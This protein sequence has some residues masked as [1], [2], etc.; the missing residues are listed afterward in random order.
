M[1][2]SNYLGL[3]LFLILC[4]SCD[5]DAATVIEEPILISAITME[6]AGFEKD[7]MGWP[8]DWWHK[9]EP[10]EVRWDSDQAY[11]GDGSVAIESDTLVDGFNFWGQTMAQNVQTGRKLR[12]RVKVKLDQVRGEGVSI[13]IRG[14][15][16]FSPEGNAEAFVT[17]QGTV[18]ISGT[19]N[20]QEYQVT[21]LE[22]MPESI[23]SI[24]VYLVL[25]PNTT[26]TVWFDEVKLEY[27]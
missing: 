16:T 18:Y 6:N 27:L 14:D 20:W 13:V 26:G 8:S 9:T 25:L 10:Y 2:K 12:L 11:D 1:K 17:T 24:T 22:N 5:K 3:F 7:P 21:Q 4:L 23:N 15:D 19:H